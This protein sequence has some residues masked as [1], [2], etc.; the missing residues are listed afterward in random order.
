MGIFSKK[1]I[2]LDYAS[3]TPIDERVLRTINKYSQ[4]KYANPSSWYL[5][6]VN[7]KK[8]LEDSRNIVAKTITA[9]ADEI[10]FTG[11][12]T[13]SNNIAI[14][15]IVEAQKVKGIDYR[16]MHIISSTIEHSSVLECFNHLKTK[17]V[18]VDFVTV[19]SDG[20]VN[21]DEL[22]KLIKPTTILVSVMMVNNEMGSVQPIRDIAKIIRKARSEKINSNRT[23][24]NAT[25]F[26]IFHTD[27][28]QAFLY[29][30]INMQ[31]LG[32]D[33]LTL[34]GSKVYG[35]RGVGALYIRRG[36][37]IKPIIFGGG[38]EGGIRSG[39]EN[40]P[41][42]AGFTTALSIARVERGTEITRIEEL[43]QQFISGLK[44]I[45]NDI[46]I[47]GSAGHIISATIHGIDSEFFVMQ[48]DAKGVS[49]STKSSCLR[50]G[51]ESYVLESIGVDSKSTVRFS[52][53]RNTNSRE[54]KKVLGLIRG[55][56]LA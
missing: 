45:K 50:D 36:L 26:P 22:K 1:R 19:D 4:N 8:V 31:N 32:V 42:I 10:V 30:E 47:N 48:L 21:L 3:L 2:Y 56:I 14:L 51:D 29:Q 41:S 16:D 44:N 55:I 39:T 25:I 54:I 52:I 23:D 20:V 53:G 11:G 9:H 24:V 43:R 12:G 38:Q 46:Q 17:G 35:P 34:D 18:N 5:E 7:A 37:N 28:S 15:G 6:G 33:M 27:A 49:C 13:E 40:I